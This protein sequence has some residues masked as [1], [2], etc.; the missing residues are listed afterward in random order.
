PNMPTG[1][2]ASKELFSRLVR[3]ARKHHILICNDNPYSF[4]LYDKP[5]SIFQAEGARE[6]AVELNSLSKSH[7]M[8]G[9]RVGMLG[10]REDYIQTVQKVNSNVH[11]G[12]FYAVQQAAVQ[13]RTCPNAHWSFPS[14]RSGCNLHGRQP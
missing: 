7:N 13:R 5:Q 8:A 9:W 1:A 14:A 3:F 6:V 10:G 2:P 12:M 11:S 4:V